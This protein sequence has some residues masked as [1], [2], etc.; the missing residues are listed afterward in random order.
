MTGTETTDNTSTLRSYAS[1]RSL[2]DHHIPTSELE[3]GVMNNQDHSGTDKRGDVLNL[4]PVLDGT[5]TTTKANT[6]NV[7]ASAPVSPIDRSE[8]SKART[9][10][11][12][13]PTDHYDGRIPSNRGPPRSALP[14]FLPPAKSEPASNGTAISS[15]APV[16]AY[17]QPK[18]HAT[19]Q[20][21]PQAGPS[22]PPK[23]LLSTYMRD[24]PDDT[25]RDAIKERF[26]PPNPLIR[27]FKRFRIKHSVIEGM[28]QDE[29]DHW[30]AQRETL[31]QK[32]GWKMQGT[33]GPGTEVSELYWK[34]SFITSKRRLMQ[35]VPLF[36]A[37]PR[38]RSAFRIGTT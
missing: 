2:L 33:E 12:V 35:D 3:L 17:D 37:Y 22:G 28:T 4:G 10:P 5:N 26:P 18:P 32:A 21:Q 36:D 15:P 38:K 34:V 31:M 16:G 29:M 23:R 25:V 27:L 13:I 14:D 8:A 1:R 24:H 30:E 9:T 6:N 19:Q 11:L 20:N 7:S